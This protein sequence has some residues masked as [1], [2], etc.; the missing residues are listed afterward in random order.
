MKARAFRRFFDHGH[1]VGGGEIAG[2]A[3]FVED[4]NLAAKAVGEN[5]RVPVRR[6][7]GHAPAKAGKDAPEIVGRPPGVFFLHFGFPVGTVVFPQQ[8]LRRPFGGKA[9]T[10][11]TERGDGLFLDEEPA[12][13]FFLQRA[14][15]FGE[16]DEQ[17]GVAHGVGRIALPFRLQVEEDELVVRL[18]AEIAHDHHAALLQAGHVVFQRVH[19]MIAVVAVESVHMVQNAGIEDAVEGAERRIGTFNVSLNKC[20]VGKFVFFLRAL[21]GIGVDVDAHR[22]HA[23]VR[24]RKAEGTE[25]GT[26]AHVGDDGARTR[27]EVRGDDGQLLPHGFFHAFEV[28]VVV[29]A[30]LRGVALRFFGL[31]HA[32]I[33]LFSC[34][35]MMSRNIL[36]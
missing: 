7:V 9:E 20:Q 16:K 24:L 26:A 10:A 34:W 6:G 23:G 31:G 19:D 11:V 35:R 29:G 4:F 25:A 1:E 30:R 13:A 27:Q 36:P 5:P 28:A 14:G 2:R 12:V 22:L 15:V 33:S 32:V 8:E 3:V 17:V 21:D 18:R